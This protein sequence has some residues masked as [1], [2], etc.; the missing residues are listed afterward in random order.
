[1]ATKIVLKHGTGIPSADDLEVGEI[2]IDLT[3]NTM[4]TKNGLGNV[5]Q[6]GGASGGSDPV[7]WGD[8]LNVPDSFPPTS[9]NHST[10]Q[11]TGLDATLS[12]I[13]DELDELESMIDATMDQLAFGGT[14]DAAD[15]K[16]S[17][18]VK[19]GINDGDSLPDPT[20]FPSTFLICV[21]A[22]D[23]PAAGM[24]TGDW[25][26]SDGVTWHPVMYETAGGV[27]WENI[28]NKPTEF[29]VEAHTH[30]IDDVT[31]LQTELDGKAGTTHSHEIE[32][33]TGLQ[34]ALDAKLDADG[35]F[36]YGGTF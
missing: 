4:Y 2:G 24:T 31:G 6:L 21:V 16:I 29:P 35:G 18:G 23:N 9:H 20:Q 27:A 1:M 32:D 14:W 12:G 10:D 19:N 33:I 11:I 30:V 3:N 17:D 36:I 26:V 7:D 28:V 5:V 13:R 15:G 8:I 25:L 34:A 22:G